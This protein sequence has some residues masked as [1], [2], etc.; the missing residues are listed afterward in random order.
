MTAQELYSVL[1]CLF[2]DK[3]KR[4]FLQLS[5]TI[6]TCNTINNEFLI[7]RIRTQYINEKITKQSFLIF[8]PREEEKRGERTC[9]VVL[10]N[11]YGERT[12]RKYILIFIGKI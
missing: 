3:Q 8:P 2:K 12:R 7:D 9:A 10:V 5:V 1:V 4:Y 11:I 6:I